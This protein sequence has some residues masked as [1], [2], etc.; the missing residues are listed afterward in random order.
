MKQLQVF[1]ALVLF[2]A[3]AGVSR[4]GS[5]GTVSE[6]ASGIVTTLPLTAIQVGSD[7]EVAFR[8]FGI[9]VDTSDAIDFSQQGFGWTQVAGGTWTQLGTQ[10]IWYRDAAGENEPNVEDVGSFVSVDAPWITTGDFTILSADG[11]LS[12]VITLFNVGNDAHLTFASDPIAPA[13]ST[14]L[15]GLALLGVVG[16]GS[17]LRRKAKAVA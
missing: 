13:P 10:S 6:T 1:T 16:G 2:V 12:D 17:F 7:G 8:P 11:S 3:F 4:A 14:A 15:S 9:T 5:L